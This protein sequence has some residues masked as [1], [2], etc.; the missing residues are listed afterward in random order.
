MNLDEVETKIGPDTLAVIAVHLF[1]IPENIIELKGMAQKRGII[2]IE[3]AAQAF[4]NKVHLSPQPSPLHAYGH[5][6]SFGDIGILSFGRGK[7]LSLLGGGAVLINNQEVEAIAKKQFDL[8]PE[9][10]H[11]LSGLRHLIN[12]SL[13]SFFYHPN[14]YPIPQR[15]PGL[16]LGET[17]FTLDFPTEKMNSWVLRVGNKLM[18]QF[19]SIRK[20]RLELMRIYAEKLGPLKDEFAFF[21]K[22]NGEDI[23]LLRFPIVFMD[24]EKRDR[25]LIELKKKGLGAT[26]MYPVPLNEQEGV[27]PYLLGSKA[28]PNAKFVSERILTLPIHEHVR[29]EDVERIREIIRKHF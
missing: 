22:F 4:G 21:P 12:L 19:D 26:G 29:V 8:L 27:S 25:I 2:L 18:P 3:D 11:L 1:G 20:R 16:K 24:R 13:Y 10:D 17:I 7:P 6:G 5:L 23:A 9:S 14:L 28:C 15:M